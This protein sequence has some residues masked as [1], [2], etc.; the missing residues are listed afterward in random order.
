M[1]LDLLIM[2]VFLLILFPQ[3]HQTAVSPNFPK[4]HCYNL[5]YNN[6]FMSF[7][8]ISYVVTSLPHPHSH[9]QYLYLLFKYSF[10]V[11]VIIINLWY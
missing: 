5:A 11:A 6:A 9:S 8:M 10:G 7:A 3:M 4:L 2:Q 1:L